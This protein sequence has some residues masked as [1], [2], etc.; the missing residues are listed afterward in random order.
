MPSSKEQ[1]RPD[2]HRRVPTEQS[3]SSGIDRNVTDLINSVVVTVAGVYE[4]T[5]SPII[6]TVTGLVILIMGLSVGPH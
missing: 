4:L 1:Y 3:E 5:G 2:D 6:S